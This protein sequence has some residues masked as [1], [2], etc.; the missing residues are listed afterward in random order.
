LPYYILI[1]EPLDLHRFLDGHFETGRCG[2]AGALTGGQ[3]LVDDLL[4]MVY[5]IFTD[6]AFLPGNKDL[7]LIPAAA[8]K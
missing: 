6:M 7:D 5:A 2:I 1:Q 4:C 8:A 3:F